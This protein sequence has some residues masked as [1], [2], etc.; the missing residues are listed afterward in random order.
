MGRPSLNPIADSANF[1][2]DGDPANP[3]L[4][5]SGAWRLYG[6]IDDEHS[7]MAHKCSKR[8]KDGSG[9]VHEMGDDAPEWRWYWGQGTC[10]NCHETAPNDIV[11]VW[12]LHNFDRISEMK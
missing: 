11:A 1:S 2:A 12:T 7:T 8:A 6:H 9:G 4:F 10:G 3:V 5:E